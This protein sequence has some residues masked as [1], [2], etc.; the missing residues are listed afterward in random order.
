MA[1]GVRLLLCAAPAAALTVDSSPQGS[2]A[3][4]PHRWA[5]QR[6]G[7]GGEEAAAEKCAVCTMN[8]NKA[9]QLYIEGRGDGLGNTMEA[10]IYGMAM[11]AHVG[12]NFGGVIHGQHTSHKVDTAQAVANAFGV[13][14]ARI[15]P[16]KPEMTTVAATWREIVAP[17][18]GKRSSLGDRVFYE[19]NLPQFGIKDEPVEKYLT[20][21]FLATMRSQVMPR[22]AQIFPLDQIHPPSR[23]MMVAFHVRRG[24]VKDLPEGGAWGRFTPNEWYYSLMERIQK[25]DPQA[26]FHIWSSL[27][28]ADNQIDEARNSTFDGFRQRG[29]TVH[30]DTDEVETWAQ[31][32]QAD[33]FVGAKSSFSFFPSLLTKGC[34]LYQK[35]LTRG[36]STFVDADIKKGPSDEGLKRCMELASAAKSARQ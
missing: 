14:K 19:S 9:P 28:G 33:V 24:D 5:H 8:G 20:P 1:A 18:S 17:A 12:M 26:D 23:G 7:S 27:R 25:Y 35:W 29:V 15:F 36:L 11:S 21:E 31:M 10:V 6:G 16:A 32:S 4:W 3:I 13:S 2:A 34:V 30:L 22:F